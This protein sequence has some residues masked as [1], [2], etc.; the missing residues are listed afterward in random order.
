MMKQTTELL[1][2]LEKTESMINRSVCALEKYGVEDWIE[3][4]IKLQAMIE[5]V[6]KGKSD[7]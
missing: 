1:A 5:E 7:D 6:K 3:L 2:L 4:L